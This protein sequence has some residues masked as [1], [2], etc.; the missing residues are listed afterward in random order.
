MGHKD[1]F[2]GSFFSMSYV[3]FLFCVIF[4]ITA[5]GWLLPLSSVMAGYILGVV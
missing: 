4:G 2:R 3:N 5:G 1:Y